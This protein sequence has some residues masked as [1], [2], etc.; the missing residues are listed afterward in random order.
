MA[1]GRQEEK[2][3]PAAGASPDGEGAFRRFLAI[4]GVG[5]GSRASLTGEAE[6]AFRQADAILAAGRVLPMLEAF[7]KPMGQAYRADQVRAYAREHP[8][9]RS[10]AVGVSGDVGFYSGAKKMR[11]ELPDWDVRL[12]PGVASP[13]Y[14][15]ARLGIP[16]EDVKLVSLHGRQANLPAAVRRHRRVFALAG[17]KECGAGEICRQLLDFGLG[18]VRVTVGQNLSYPEETIRA[19][20]PE[21]LRAGRGRVSR[22]F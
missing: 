7:G 16:W 19:G 10:L 8:H 6:E 1:E 15:C 9:C 14:F 2:P 13:V 11:E 20:T 5:M 18:A 3:V 17:G 22:F 12:V 21:E 4:V